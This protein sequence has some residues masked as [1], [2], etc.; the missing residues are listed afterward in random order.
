MALNQDTGNTSVSIMLNA[1]PDLLP[2]NTSSRLW[3]LASSSSANSNLASSSS[4]SVNFADATALGTLVDA[5]FGRCSPSYPVLH[6]RLLERNS[7]ISTKFTPGPV[8]TLYS[9][10][11]LQSAI[12]GAKPETEQSRYYKAAR[13]CMSMRILE[14]GTLLAVQAALPMVCS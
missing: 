7:I 10:L 9:I 11:Y 5:Y 3:R 8:G 1:T 14:S 13:S 12:G 2:D 6:E 4:Q